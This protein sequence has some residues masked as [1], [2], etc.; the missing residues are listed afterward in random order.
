MSKAL[1][2]VDFPYLRLDEESLACFF[3]TLPKGFSG[4]GE[5][6]FGIEVSLFFMVSQVL[7]IFVKFVP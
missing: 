6:W 5:I 7:T 2:A 4:F 1:H 3:I